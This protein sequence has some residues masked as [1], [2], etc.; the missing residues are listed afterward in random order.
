M[1]EQF[2]LTCRQMEA[3]VSGLADPSIFAVSC[4]FI[5]WAWFYYPDRLPRAYNKWIGSAAAVD[6]RLIAALQR[7]RSKELQYGE[8]TGQAPLLQGMCEDFGW[9]LEWGDPAKSIP[10]P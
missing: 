7:C 2:A 1:A 5:M 4:A 8:D 9:P 3:I 10:F 6:G